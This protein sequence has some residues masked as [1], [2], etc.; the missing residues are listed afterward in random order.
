M[1]VTYTIIEHEENNE[2]KFW[3]ET[4][5]KLMAETNLSVFKTWETV[6]GIPIYNPNEFFEQYCPEV[7]A[8]LGE[9][10]ELWK[11]VLKEPFFGHTEESYEEAKQFAFQGTVECTPWT[12]KS[13]HHIL[14][15]EKIIGKSILDYDQI[16]DFGSGIGE[17]ARMILDLGFEGDYYIYDLPETARIP[18]EYLKN[19]KN[20]KFVEHYNEVPNDKKTLFIGTWSLSEVPYSYRKEIGNYFAGQTFLIIFQNQVFKYNN[21]NYFIADFPKESNTFIRLQQITWHSGGNGNYY[22]IAT[23][24]N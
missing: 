1:G 7:E 13:A 24:P 17:T 14:T 11:T 3:T 23:S 5:K 21:A 15:F 19:Y 8:M 10:S 20:I 22:L 16:V 12:L 18:K 4:K 2:N 6:R 9:P